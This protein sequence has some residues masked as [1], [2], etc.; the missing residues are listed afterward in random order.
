MKSLRYNDSCDF[1][2]GLK[3]A[4]EWQGYVFNLIKIL[5]ALPDDP[6]VLCDT[7]SVFRCGYVLIKM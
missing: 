6:V 7:G 5:M 3:G 1:F 2:F 4:G